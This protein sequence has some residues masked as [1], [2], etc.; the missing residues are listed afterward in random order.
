MSD[1]AIAALERCRMTWAVF[2]AATDSSMA[3]AGAEDAKAVRE[4]LR[5]APAS[6]E[7][8]RAVVT[9]LIERYDAGDVPLELHMGHNADGTGDLAA[10]VFLRSLLAGLQNINT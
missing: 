6:L 8:V 9:H 7:T 3:H 4:L 5:L 10:A 2:M 1:P